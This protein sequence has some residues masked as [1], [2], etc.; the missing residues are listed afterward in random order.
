MPVS[1]HAAKGASSAARWIACPGSIRAVDELPKEEHDGGSVYSRE[2]N[3][4]HYLA[5]QC[6]IKHRD[7]MEYIGLWIS[8]FGVI[9]E[10]TEEPTTNGGCWF[11]ID[12]EMADSVQLYIDVIAEHRERLGNAE[13]MCERTVY[14]VRGME[15]EMYGTL[16]Y[17]LHEPGGELVV[18][19]FKYGKGIAVSVEDNKQEKCYALG[20]LHLIG[21]PDDVSKVTLVI[22][23]PRGRH[24]DGP[25][26]SWSLSPHELAAYEDE[27]REASI[28]AD[29]PDAPLVPGT[30]CHE[31][32]CPAAPRCPALQA[33]V[34]E[35]T[36]AA[37]PDDIDLPAAPAKP[38]DLRVHAR[39]PHAKDPLELSA[40]MKVTELVEFWVREVKSRVHSALEGGMKVP[41]WKLAEGR[42][43][44]RWGDAKD[45]ERRLRNMAN[46]KVDDIYEPRKLRSPAQLQKNK[47]IGKAWVAK[48][49]VK[50][51]GKVTVVPDFD[52]RPQLPA[53]VDALDE[54]KD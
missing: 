40:A 37:F 13:E 4:A 44:R 28:R 21:G 3:A 29:A 33:V 41:G 23:Q 15:G 52:S 49:V 5:E 53:M 35:Q 50:P 14:P 10:T 9:S 27:L 38:E 1:V 2:G 7:P 43:H 34:L 47:K 31:Y 30:H 48:H 32:F 18:A 11:V 17:A 39:L 6:L 36:I 24:P 54:I 51:P 12:D 8:S 46:V 22:V 20:A 26:R 25:V 19:D 42:S 45:V 16:D